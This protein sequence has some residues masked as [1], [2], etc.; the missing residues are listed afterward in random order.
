MQPMKWSCSSG[1][2]RPSS[3]SWWTS[4]QR[5]RPSL[6]QQPR[7]CSTRRTLAL[8]RAAGDGLSFATREVADIVDLVS[9]KNAEEALRSL[10]SKSAAAGKD[11]DR[12]NCE[13]DADDIS[14]MQKE[15]VALRK[16]KKYVNKTLELC[17]KELKKH[18]AASTTP[19]QKDVPPTSTPK[20]GK[21][22]SP[23]ANVDGGGEE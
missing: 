3:A 17:R 22:H 20:R 8:Q 9:Q 11:K 1:T 10:S 16:D 15:L 21:K 18:D 2:S 4:M 5:A 13:A 12:A 23:A 19:K 14:K 7:S 6:Q